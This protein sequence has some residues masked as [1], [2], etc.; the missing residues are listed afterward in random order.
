MGAK[1]KEGVS[2]A[3]FLTRAATRLYCGLFG[4]QYYTVQRFNKYSRKIACGR[5]GSSFAMD[6]FM[7]VVV[8]WS[9]DFEHLYY[10]VY[11]FKKR[12]NYE[13]DSNSKQ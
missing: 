13:K 12:G 8:P 5:C 1:Q 6:D 3:G 9:D 4:H 10:V 2:L 11:G 7:Q